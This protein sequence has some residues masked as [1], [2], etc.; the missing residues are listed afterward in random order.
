MI[1]VLKDPQNALI[2][3]YQKIFEMEKVKLKFTEDTLTAIAQK[4]ITQGTGARGLRAILEDAMLDIMYDLPSQ[5]STV[6]ECV[7]TKD[8]TKGKG[9]PILLYEKAS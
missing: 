5:S 4:A 7:I 9:T 3:Q 8:V 2:K 1:S 6:K